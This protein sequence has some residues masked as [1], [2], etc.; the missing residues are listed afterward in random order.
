M[1]LV[2]G[3]PLFYYGPTPAIKLL[4]TGSKGYDPKFHPRDLLEHMANGKSRSEVCA[5]WGI[6]YS[7]FNEWLETHREL[8]DAYAVGKPAYDGYYKKAL[9]DT[10]FGAAKGV[11]ENSMFFMLKNVAGFSDNDGGHDYADAQGAELD[12]ET[13]GDL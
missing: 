9:R 12:F 3:Q 4:Y 8:S 1:G 6:T 2:E 5:A 13:E 7:M 10:A 11:R